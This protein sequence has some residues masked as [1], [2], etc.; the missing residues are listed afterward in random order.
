MKER[1]CISTC[2]RFKDYVVNG[3]SKPYVSLQIGAGAG[4]DTKLAGKIWNSETTIEDT[5][6]AYEIVGCDAL[7]LTGLPSFNQI[8]KE[9]SWQVKTDFSQT[10]RMTEQSLTTPYGQLYWKFH[11]VPKTGT[12][13]VVYPVNADDEKGFDKIQWYAT[14][15]TKALKYIGE[16][17]RP[18]IEKIKQYGAVCV[19]WNLQPF[20][21]LG[22]ASVDNLV[23]MAKIDPE[24]YRST[25]DLIRDINIELLREV[26]KAGADF[27]FV[28]GPGV[29]MMSPEYYKTYIIPDSQ[30]IAD[31]T[32]SSGGL[33]YS[34]ICSPIEPFLTM[35]FY[36]EMKLDLFE[37][38]S[39]PPVGNVADLA[40][41]RKIL[42]SKMCT[43]GN[44]GL[45][46]LLTGT[47]EDVETE[48]LRILE[49][50]KGTKHMVAASDYLFYDIPVENA[51]AVVDTVRHYKS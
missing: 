4:F 30:K 26:F 35:G 24:R 44:I 5:A 31:A 3:S 42:D 49:A 41:A 29:E 39:P 2:Q 12:T 13:P 32:H 17:L 21:L 27:V 22:L 40:K 28:G 15:H 16:L 37:T 34:H 11:E 48:T 19:Q 23:L 25:C 7:F 8:V 33:I 18:G 9:L 10:C 45:D 14:Q 43:R 47:K 1:C 36:N 51:K 50:T 6:K 46:V 38:L 20:E